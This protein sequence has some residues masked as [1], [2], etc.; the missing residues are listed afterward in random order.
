MVSDVDKAHRFNYFSSVF[1]IEDVS[2]LDSISRELDVDDSPILLDSV[3]T[4]ITEVSELLNS[5]N[6]NKSCGPDFVYA[7]LLKEGATEL[8]PSLTALFNKSPRCNPST[9]LGEC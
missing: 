7:R 5:L 9:G 8:A 3:E 2:A 6:V 1:T 4:S